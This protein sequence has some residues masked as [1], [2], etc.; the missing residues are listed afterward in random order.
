MDHFSEE[1]TTHCCRFSQPFML[2]Y[3]KVGD[4]PYRTIVFYSAIE[5]AAMGL[6]KLQSISIYVLYLK[7]KR[8]HLLTS[9]NYTVTPP[10]LPH[11]R[12]FPYNCNFITN[13]L[14]IY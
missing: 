10:I 9:I 11:P 14:F 6:C 13:I 4:F 5:E 2:D 12:H 1:V 3:S 7:K 8:T